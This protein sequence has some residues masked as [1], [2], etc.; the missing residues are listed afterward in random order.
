M[1]AIVFTLQNPVQPEPKPDRIVLP[2]LMQW[3]QYEDLVQELDASDWNDRES[4]TWKL[5]RA[6][7][8]VPSR[9]IEMSLEEGGLSLEQVMRLLRVME[10]R[11]L[12]APRGALGIQMPINRIGQQREVRRE[13]PRGVEVSA[14]IPGLPAE[15]ILQAGD[16]ITHIDGKPLNQREDL[17]LIVQRHWPGD[18]NE[19]PLPQ[20]GGLVREDQRVH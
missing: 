13:E 3:D 5:A 7:A 6:T 18:E 1:L 17:A 20:V 8:E 4:A 16:V 9:W 14:V 15:K 10:I 11:L 19:G 2:G 12:H